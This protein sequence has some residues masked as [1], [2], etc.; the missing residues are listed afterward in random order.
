MKDK[1][2]KQKSSKSD[3][4]SNCYHVIDACGCKVGSYCCE[5]SD[6]SKCSFHKCC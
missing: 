5:G 3:V 2:K 6:M 1:D 4:K